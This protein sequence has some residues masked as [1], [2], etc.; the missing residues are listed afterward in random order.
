MSFKF[1]RQIWP[2][3]ER[4]SILSRQAYDGLQ[5]IEISQWMEVLFHVRSTLS[6]SNF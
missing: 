2:K 4:T 3:E 6:L 5:I 1:S